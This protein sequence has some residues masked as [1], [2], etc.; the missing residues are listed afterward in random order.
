MGPPPLEALTSAVHGGLAGVTRNAPQALSARQQ[1]G[2]HLTL[3]NAFEL[4]CDDRLVPLPRP[5]QR[6]LAFLALQDRAVHRAYVA[7]TL[8][9]EASQDHAFGSLR[10]ALWRAQR[11][12][13]ELI[14]K[15]ATQLRLGSS[16]AV[17]I[18]ETIAWAR[19]VLNGSGEP[20]ISSHMGD[21]LPDWY[22]EWV[23][24]ERERLRELRVRALEFLCAELTVAGS[25]HQA[26]EAGLAAVGD[27]PLR[28]SAHRT[29]ITVY[30]AEGNHAEAIRRYRR[31]RALLQ[32]QLGLEPSGRMK[33]L[34][35]GLGPDDRA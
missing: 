21:L 13:H 3:L 35:G 32:D 12:G 31:Y 8:W 22:D 25:F 29:L 18:R 6:L 19:D 5:A 14:E 33:A 2:P 23:L 16:V 1:S 11:C 26:V 20:G 27:E 10:S 9:P 7:G 34:I 30:L 4:R 28:E 15:T 17:D 24:L